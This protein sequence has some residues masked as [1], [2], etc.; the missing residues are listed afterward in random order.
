MFTA[1]DYEYSFN[2]TACIISPHLNRKPHK[3]QKFRNAASEV[4]NNNNR[5]KNH[6]IV[7]TTLAANL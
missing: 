2:K 5:K 3:D 1:D 4:N 6:E 7:T